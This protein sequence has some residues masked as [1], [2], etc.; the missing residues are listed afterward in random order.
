M[1]IKTYCMYDKKPVYHCHPTG[2]RFV[3]LTRLQTKN[4]SKTINILLIL[5]IHHYA[6]VIL[7]MYS[8]K[9]CYRE[10]SYIFT[11]SEIYHNDIMLNFSKLNVGN[12]KR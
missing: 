2:F 12:K 1:P 3:L 5:E 6:K 8:I 7:E 4:K 10:I 11:K 9:N